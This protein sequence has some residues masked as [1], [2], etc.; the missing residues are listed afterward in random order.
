MRNLLWIVALH[1]AQLSHIHKISKTILI[2]S[3][4]LKYYCFKK[5]KKRKMK[6]VGTDS[7]SGLKYANYKIIMIKI[8]SC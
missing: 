2:K 6:N 1:V 8:L 5:K 3:Q 7:Y 4:L